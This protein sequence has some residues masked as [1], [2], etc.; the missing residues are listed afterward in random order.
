M[1]RGSWS[2]EPDSGP[3][4][5]RYDFA[6]PLDP[7]RLA[8]VRATGLLDA[9][10]V[11][12]LDRLARLAGRVLDAPIALVTLIDAERQLFVAQ[13]GLG[14]PWSSRR[15]APLSHAICLHV[16][17]AGAPLVVDD[18]RD[19]ALVHDS[20][21]I[22]DF[23]VVAYLGTPLRDAAGQVLGS[24]CLMD[25]E[26]RAWT[27]G[28]LA[29]LQELAGTAAMVVAQHAAARALAE[30]PQR[31]AT[32]ARERA[33]LA[34]T[35]ESLSDA[36]VTCDAEGRLAL[37]NGAARELHGA[38]DAALG[39]DRWAAHYHLF[40]GDGA[41]PLPTEEHPLVRA[42]VGDVVRDAELVIAPPGG[43][44]RRVRAS[45]RAIHA[46]DGA[47]LGAAVALRDVT[48]A[49]RSEARWRANEVRY[50]MA[51]DGGGLAYAALRTVRDA[52]DSIVDFEYVEV[53]ETFEALF[54]RIA[55]DAVGARLT[56]LWPDARADGTFEEY[57]R[58]AATGE[59][60]AAER[61]TRDPHTSASWIG[62]QVMPI[63]DGVAMLARDLSREKAAEEDRRVLF[64]V[65]GALSRAPDA[66]HAISAALAAMCAASGCEYGEAWLAPAG[67]AR[68][69]ETL[70]R[71]PVWHAPDDARLTE[72]AGAS[73]AHA[74]AA[75]GGLPGRVWAAAAPI[76]L[77][78]LDEPDA[79]YLPADEARAAGLRTGVGIPVLADGAVVAV[80][81]FLARGG[82]CI[83][84]SQID[85]LCAVAVQLGAVVRRQLA[86]AALR[87]SEAQ[88]RGV[89][90]TVRA[91][92]VTLDAAGC[93]TFANDAL[94][95]LGGWT[96][97]EVVGR[98]WFTHVLAD[99]ERVR[100]LFHDMLRDGGAAPPFEC[101]LLT[102]DGSRR[103]VAW[104]TTLLRDAS[105]AV[106]GTA[107]IGH[108]VTEQRA[109]EQRLAT[110]SEHDELTGLL[111]RRGFRRMLQQAVKAA[112]RTGARDALL[113]LDL[114][115]FKPIND[116]YGHPEGD[117]ALRAVAGVLRT[118]IRD[119]DF[120]G[121][122]GG[123]EFAVFA[124]GLRASGEGHVLAARLQAALAAH[125]RDATAAGR[126]YEI[127]FSVGVA[128]VEPGDTPETLLARADAALYARKLSRR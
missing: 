18:A 116:T 66:S 8:A 29:T 7:R 109:L 122:F 47:M 63:E 115:R 31:Q 46:S 41:T 102:R 64:E 69:A 71:G 61:R 100:S 20:A 89:L 62:V 33:V 11:P 73:R 94:L 67:G 83:A 27:P 121:R 10:P 35:I 79:A 77:P 38:P 50:R 59:P 126:P 48:A 34:A 39:P 13:H 96:R 55:E 103:L 32:L 19:H 101:E 82:R 56:A 43:R 22:A 114:D 84:Q 21:A 104:D 87:E 70:T 78:T 49:A 98:D 99:G 42:F 107:S 75:G 68:G 88:F 1:S 86:E 127:G 30:P 28:D 44:V 112:N 108:D 9:P 17:A 36:V 125:N 74:S 4:P 51:L 57:R 54:G 80:L 23:G 65:T 58:V 45:G 6:R 106:I 93:V 117:A 118:T 40:R 60:F 92:A 26:P 113:F 90:E 72:F 25:P 85:R 81:A 97:A 12:A 119:A 3:T 105:G 110:L 120:A 76:V 15:E 53:N 24:V 2:A 14:A 111:N 16:V 52:A 37:F 124:V 5:P 91:A 123:D 128:E 95:V